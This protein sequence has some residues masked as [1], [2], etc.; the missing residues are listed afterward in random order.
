MINDVLPNTVVHGLDIALC[1]P[2]V[3]QS[4]FIAFDFLVWFDDIRQG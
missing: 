3:L 2:P 1:N 4:V